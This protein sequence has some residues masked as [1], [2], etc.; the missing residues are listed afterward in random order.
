MRDA[1]GMQSTQRDV[2]TQQ[3]GRSIYRDREIAITSVSGRVRI[4]AIG[5]QTILPDIPRALSVLW[6]ADGYVSAAT[7]VSARQQLLYVNNPKPQPVMPLCSQDSRLAKKVSC[8]NISWHVNAHFENEV[9]TEQ[10]TP[11]RAKRVDVEMDE[12]T[13]T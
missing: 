2:A 5:L 4:V 6:N 13:H 8:R 9:V 12:I 10:V 1:D 11:K 3:A 7:V